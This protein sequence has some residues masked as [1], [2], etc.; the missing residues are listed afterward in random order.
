MPGHAYAIPSAADRIV[1]EVLNGSRQSGAARLGTR[2]LRGRG[3]DVV[4]LGNAAETVSATRVIARR[5]GPGPAEQVR[6]ALGVGTV[7][8][9]PDTLRRVDVTVVLGPDFLPAD[10]T[11]P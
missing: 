2:H 4:Y 1:V 6:E 11:R 7:A 8:S 3:F 10:D 9:E 5:G